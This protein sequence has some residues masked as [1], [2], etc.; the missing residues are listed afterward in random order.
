MLNTCEL[1]KEYACNLVQGN[2]TCNGDITSE[3]TE[4]K[5]HVILFWSI[6]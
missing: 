5:T 6:F 2:M 1:Y 4:S 3:Y